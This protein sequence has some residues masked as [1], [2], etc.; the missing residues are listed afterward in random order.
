MTPAEHDVAV[1]GAGPVGLFFALCAVAEGLRPIV[2]ERRPHP[3]LESR[4]IGIHPPALEL[5]D[6]L[7]VADRFVARGVRVP[8]GR[9]FGTSGSLGA[10]AFD[11]LPGRHRYVLAL[12]Q[13][14][15]EAILTE[16][17]EERAPAAI[18]RGFGVTGLRHELNAE[19]QLTDQRGAVSTLT[20]ACV[21]ACDGKHSVV[22]ALCGIGF[23]G[24]MY[25]GAYAMGDYPDTTPF[26]CDAAVFLTAGGLVE[27]FPLPGRQRRWVVRREND[28]AAAQP[29]AD[30]VAS[31]VA[32]R[33]GFR[34]PADEARG[35]SG[36]RA[37]R[38]IASSL[39]HGPVALAGDAGHVVSPIGGQGMNLGWLGAADLAGSIGDAMHSG[40]DLHA[41]LQ[42]SSARRLRVA[43]AVRR[44]AE[45]NMWLGRPT[46]RAKG[47]DRLV[48]SLLATSTG[49][50]LARAFTMRGLGLGV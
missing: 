39:A 9:A 13:A 35:V 6:R 12:P 40:R 26:G 31:I 41:T 20:A 5:L 11:R 44:R 27:S 17:L 18:R 4:A 47:R 38:W 8:R 15:T 33:T 37:E 28:N 10:V 1:V 42:A 24:A 22:R 21:V 34:L 48:S 50:L 46:L 45:V 29:T 23:D 7:G 19:L 25:D 32:D 49:P 43:R 2:I 14:E 3:R 36:F 16:A 30:E